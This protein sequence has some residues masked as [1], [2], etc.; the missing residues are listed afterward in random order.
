MVQCFVEQ[1]KYAGFQRDRAPKL[2]YVSRVKAE[3]CVHPRVM[4]A[5]EGFVEI[6]LIR[7]GEGYYTINGKRYQVKKGD[8][9]L[10]NGG[11]VHD[12]Y[13]SMVSIYAC[14]V[15]NILK[16]GL[17][18]NQIISD[19][20]IPVVHTGESFGAM[21]GLMGQMFYLLCGN[22]PEAKE[23]CQHLLSALLKQIEYV[24]KKS[25]EDVKETAT[26]RGILA[27]QIRNY[28][29]CNYMNDV[30]LQS[31]SK[32]LNISLYYLSHIFKE[33]Y[34]YSPMQYML[35]RRIG[36]AQSLLIGTDLTV[37]RI[38]MLVGYDN[39]NHFIT[40][41]SKN[42]GISPRNYR[43]LYRAK[44]KEDLTYTVV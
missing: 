26:D 22:L 3:D 11:V 38:A 44:E 33:F 7:E 27:D 34:G 20:Q 36:E 31:M 2:V 14:A 5:H 12:E 42:V 23:C 41:F 17:L 13:G 1:K 19:T 35:R 21:D 37:T 9:I 15:S 40:I 16:E 8:M 32:E 4:H 24:L 18:E 6:L 10:L 25:M 29:D 28:I 43:L 30:S 39:S